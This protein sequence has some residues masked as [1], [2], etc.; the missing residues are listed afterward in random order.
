MSIWAKLDRCQH[1]GDLSEVAAEVR[2]HVKGNFSDLKEKQIKDLLDK[3]LWRDQKALLKSRADA[4][5]SSA[6]R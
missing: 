5:S 6:S 2:A 4:A 3:K 1:Y